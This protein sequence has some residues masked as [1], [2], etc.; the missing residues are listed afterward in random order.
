MNEPHHIVVDGRPMVAVPAKD[1]ESLLAMRRQL[2]SQSARMRVLR[3]ALVDMT[4]FLDGLAE[5]LDAEPSPTHDGRPGAH[6]EVV[7]D[8]RKRA[9]RVRAITRTGRGRAPRS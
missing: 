4:D 3:D 8:I 9:E 7:A 2:G 1:F 5:T 6:G